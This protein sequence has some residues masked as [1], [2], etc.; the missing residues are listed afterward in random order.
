MA[1]TIS[2]STPHTP[3]PSG[4]SAEPNASYGPP[5]PG[6]GPHT[7]SAPECSIDHRPAGQAALVSQ[8]SGSTA[9]HVGGNT[10]TGACADAVAQLVGTCGP[11]AIAI[12]AG[13]LAGGAPGV[14]IAFLSG[15]ACGYA[16]TKVTDACFADQPEPAPKAAP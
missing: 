9:A 13:T 11:A 12:G 6:S 8:Y 15:A 4:P 1:D 7:S 14:A 10:S 5:P 16:A 3:W 2:P